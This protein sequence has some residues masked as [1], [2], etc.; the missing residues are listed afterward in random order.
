MKWKMSPNSLFA[1]LLRSPWWA[2]LLIVLVFVLASIA[3]L[4]AEYRPLGMTGALPLLGI[5]LYRAWQQWQ[6]PSP[7]RVAE[8]LERAAAMPWREFSAVLQQVFQRQGFE[9]AVLPGPGADLQLSK[10][11]RSSLVS[12]KRWKAA[13]HGID[14]LRELA[15]ARQKLEADACSYIS[16]G[17][18]S[19]QAQ[20]FAKAN[21]ITLVSG[22][23]LAGLMLGAL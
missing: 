5:G 1:V 22:Q 15:T 19:D 21:G 11:G 8:T 23:E 17:P 3:L 12:C 2:S 18:V 4:P 6:A 16:L 14:A 7:K 9:V 20:S 10:A 13:S